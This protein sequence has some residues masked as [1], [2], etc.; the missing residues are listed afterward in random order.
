[1]KKYYTYLLTDSL[2]NKVFYVGKG[3]GDRAYQHTKE[4]LRNSSN[5]SNKIK[6][7]KILEIYQNGGKVIERI[8]ERFDDEMEA[9]KQEEVLIDMYGI[10]NLTNFHRSGGK[11]GGKR[12]KAFN[13]IKNM[14][15]AMDML[16][17]IDIR[18]ARKEVSI[19]IC[20]PLQ[21]LDEIDKMLRECVYMNNETH[22]AFLKES[23]KFKRVMA[24]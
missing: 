8:Y 3:Q 11:A 24:I 9:L 18:N 16:D 7:Q 6:N 14:K 22:T 1:M 10:D 13:A 19:K 2:N 21:V 5:I 15:Y 20:T 17:R 23:L 12:S 4:A